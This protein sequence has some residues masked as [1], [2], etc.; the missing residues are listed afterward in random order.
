MKT[1]L[2]S[3]ATVT[4]TVDSEAAAQ[5]LAAGAVQ[6]RLAACAQVSGPIHSVFRWEGEVR[7]ER[8]WRVE[9]KT[10]ADRTAALVEHLQ[11]AHSYDVPEIVVAEARSSAAYG[12]WVADET[13]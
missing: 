10:A 7:T 3:M 6:A 1:E 12:G 2:V 4:S 9:F 11:A 8:E 13:G 5:Q